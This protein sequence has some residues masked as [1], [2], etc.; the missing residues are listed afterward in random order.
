VDTTEDTWLSRESVFDLILIA[1]QMAAGV[2]GW[3]AYA[4][5]CS[6]DVFLVSFMLFTLFVAVIVNVR[7]RQF[8][9]ARFELAR[10]LIALLLAVGLVFWGVYSASLVAFGLVLSLGV[11]SEASLVQ[12]RKVLEK[13]PSEPTTN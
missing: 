5:S 1:I 6:F 2:L 10:K 9:S 3:L 13:P 8:K 4:F 11:W 12:V 7:H